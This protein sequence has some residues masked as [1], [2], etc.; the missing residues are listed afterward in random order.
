MSASLVGSEMCIR[1]SPWSSKVPWDF[2]VG[3]NHIGP[4]VLEAGAGD[5][6]ERD[7]DGGTGFV[8]ALV[9]PVVLD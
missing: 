5:E 2:L 9:V 1:D 7:R 4:E 6:R 3:R 8:R